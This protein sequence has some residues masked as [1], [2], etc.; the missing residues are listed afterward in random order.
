MFEK[1]QVWQMN[2]VTDNVLELIGDTPMVSLKKTTGFQI[3]AKAEFLKPGG[4]IKDRIAKNML[5]AAEAE[6]KLKKGREGREEG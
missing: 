5:E 2:I 3:F 4:S 6:G 1:G